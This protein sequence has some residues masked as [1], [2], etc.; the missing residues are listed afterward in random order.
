MTLG[1]ARRESIIV[2]AA[3]SA[4]V[5]VADYGRATFQIAQTTLRSVLGEAELDELLANREQINQRLQAIIDEL[6]DYKMLALGY[7]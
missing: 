6:E 2:P 1:R 7:A 4:V 5:E 3:E